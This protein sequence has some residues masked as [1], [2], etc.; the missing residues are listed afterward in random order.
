MMTEPQMEIFRKVLDT[1]WEMK[2]LREAGKWN[3]MMQKAKEHNAHVQE[4]KE[5]M[6]EVEYNNFI[7]LGR[8]MFAPVG[9]GGDED[10]D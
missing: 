10:E 6:G 8:K 1:N 9:G 5:L 7:N 3:E 4:L 2:E